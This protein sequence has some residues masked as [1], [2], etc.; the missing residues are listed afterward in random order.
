MS[1]KIICDSCCDIPTELYADKHYSF[2]P[3]SLYVGDEIIMDDESFDQKSFLEKVAAA[4]TASRSACPSPEDYMNQ[5]KK[6]DADMIFVITL[7]KE[8]S[9]SYNS[10]RL[11]REM[12]VEEYGH[13]NI[14][15]INSMSASCG[16]GLI[17]M[18]IQRMCEAG[19]SFN[20]IVDFVNKY[21]TEMKT[22][23][24][25]ESLDTFEKNGRLT[26]LKSK[27]VTAL[28]I[29]PVMSANFGSILQV[30][31]GRGVNMALK[32][33]IGL[34]KKHYVNTEEMEISVSHCNNPSRAQQVKEM[35]E[36]NFNFKKIYIVETKGVSS[37]YAS[38]GGII[39][40]A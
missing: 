33:M 20:Q 3:L 40:A 24:V 19:D 2:V 21:I 13:R 9:G 22:W 27:I 35:L 12:Y 18:K 30:G 32:N 5:F 36:K 16:E 29:K 38:D 25:L 8:L 23:F 31:F 6:T 28:N 1:Y 34:M 26:G 17:G 7:S 14:C 39:V 15:V 11:A 10:A 37:L 4:E